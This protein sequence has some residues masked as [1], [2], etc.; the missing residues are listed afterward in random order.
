MAIITV[1]HI[2]ERHVHSAGNSLARRTVIIVIDRDKAD[3]QKGKDLVNIIADG[4]VI[5]PKPRKI[6]YDNAANLPPSCHLK[7]FCHPWTV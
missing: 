7:Q 4:Q 6:F 3:A 2:A 5:P 1:D